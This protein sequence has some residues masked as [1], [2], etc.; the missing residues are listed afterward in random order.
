V[1]I[2]SRHPRT[3]FAGSAGTLWAPYLTLGLA[4]VASYRFLPAL[5]QL[6]AIELLAVTGT[7]AIVARLRGRPEHPLGW[8]LLA[9]VCLAFGVVGW[10][11]WQVEVAVSGVPPA[12]G[13]PA[14][15]FFFAGEALCLAA[16]VVLLLR[17]EPGSGPL[18]EAAMA[19]VA[20]GTAAWV[21]LI[22]DYVR[23]DTLAL[24]ARATQIGY[25]AC[26]VM[27]LA[28][29]VRILF[30]PGRRTGAYW[31]LTAGIGSLLSADLLWNWL[32]LAGSYAA[33]SY[34][35]LGWLL[36]LL[37]P[38]V[39]ALHPSLLFDQARRGG[40]HVGARY[41]LL[42]AGAALA[43]PLLLAVEAF[44]EVD[45]DDVAFG[46][47]STALLT[48]LV[49]A[50][51]AG[52]IR[53]ELRLSAE[54]RV[55]HE[56]LEEA[57][58]LARLGNWEWDLTEDEVSWSSGL[59][60]IW[61]LDPS[62]FTP[63]YEAFI[64]T[65]HPED[66]EFVETTLGGALDTGSA[67]FEFRVIR[68]GGEERVVHASAG[69]VRDAAGRPIRM[70]GT[71]QDVTER[72]RAESALAASETRFRTLV[73]NIPG[74]VYR[75]ALDADWTMEFLSDAIEELS[76]YPSSDF[77]GN[78]V[79]SFASI[80]HPDDEVEMERRIWDAVDAGRMYAI[81][82]RIVRADGATRWVLE[83]GQG[84]LG[85]SG[86][87]HLDGTILDITERREGELA[88]VAQNE[89][90]EEL[91]RMKDEFIALVSHELRTPL[92][93]IR[94]YLD[95]LLEGEVG[96]VTEEQQNALRV[97]DRNAERLT[98]LVGDLLFVAEVEAGKLELERRTTD[99]TAVVRDAVESARPTAESKSVALTIVVD[100][101]PTLQGDPVRLAQLL[102]NLVSNAI[103]FTPEGGQV[104]VR[105][106]VE[107]GSVSLEVTDTGMGIS[108]EDQ[109]RLFERFFRTQKA[110]AEA[111][112][113]T[114]LGLAISKAIVEAHGGTLAVA[115]KEGHGTTVRAAFPLPAP[116]GSEARQKEVAA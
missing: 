16:L 34:Y 84:V 30:S 68:P 38:G 106:Y 104:G 82:Y 75:C 50:R 66:R 48:G 51:M 6:I 40:R 44:G 55:Q 52:L 35:D 81:E 112:Q 78:R 11:F 93:S 96:E 65:V 43:A 61:E 46:A 21:F 8:R 2:P 100:E 67:E 77:I 64:A 41:L 15:V 116:H 111:I 115:S 62:E 92:T 1:S 107:D 5:G 39:A 109:R 76:G 9:L 91:D 42:L 7:A 24:A 102:D 26:D 31:L 22:H 108:A 89:R 88:L 114:G 58:R 103:K 59:Y 80:I 90:L 25:A 57:E 72:N 74:V 3:A 69:L 97:V 23:D 49:L 54:V 101:V 29:A 10:G 95:L 47:V 27:L 110:T 71:A 83:R 18:L 17:R 73:S 45:R 14:D 79:R 86:A 53:E 4:V 28:L 70:V 20:F 98:R 85:A 105:T 32:T 12:P 63:S 37:L 113:G 87:F 33:G 99:L 36:F 94:G 19:A 56:R 13:S 60:R